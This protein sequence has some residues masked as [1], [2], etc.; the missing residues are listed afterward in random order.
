MLKQLTYES[1]FIYLDIN[2]LLNEMSQD[3]PIECSIKLQYIVD[4]AYYRYE[5]Y[6]DAWV[7]SGY[8]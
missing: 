5:R 1:W 2:R 8:R 4:Q 3:L 7:N 6:R